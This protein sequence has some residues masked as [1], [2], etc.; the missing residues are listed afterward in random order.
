MRTVSAIVGLRGHWESGCIYEHTVPFLSKWQLV[1]VQWWGCCQRSVG[2]KNQ[3]LRKKTWLLQLLNFVILCV[4]FVEMYKHLKSLPPQHIATCVQFVCVPFSCTFVT[5]EVFVQLSFVECFF[6]CL[7]VSSTEHLSVSL[8]LSFPLSSPSPSFSFFEKKNKR[9]G[10]FQQLLQW[11]LAAVGVKLAE[12]P[13]PYSS[14]LSVC[15]TFVY[16]L[17]QLIKSSISRSHILS[18]VCFF[19][20][21][22][23]L[24]MTART[25]QRKPMGQQ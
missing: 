17:Q 2:E 10:T 9:S 6:F 24:H 3:G 18:F 16:R 8:S 20:K 11:P 4:G 19:K 1:P 21:R 5:V 12:L 25:P 7:F 14:S 23:G 22:H 13:S 15:S